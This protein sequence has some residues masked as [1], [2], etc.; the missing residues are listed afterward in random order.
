[1]APDSEAGTK[2]T[3]APL[4][5]ITPPFGI[6]LP[7]NALGPNEAVIANLGSGEKLVGQLQSL[8]LGQGELSMR[9]DN[10]TQ[11]ITVQI[12]AIKTLHLTKAR[13]FSPLT[14][15]NQQPGDKGASTK[16][17]KEQLTL[18]R[19]LFRFLEPLGYQRLTRDENNKQDHPP[20]PIYI[21]YVD[22][23]DKHEL[24][25]FA[26]KPGHEESNNATMRNFMVTLNKAKDVVEFIKADFPQYFEVE[27]MFKAKLIP[28]STSRDCVIFRADLDESES[29]HKLQNDLDDWFGY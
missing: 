2:Q 14:D 15:P 6:S 20:V 23:M 1:M 11:T 26:Y 9:V 10:Q 3:T 8:A 18:S 27:L 29:V 21:S 25:L 28:Q 12:E 5:E 7:A 24:M 13:Y 16:K 17:G 22:V 19:D 4:E